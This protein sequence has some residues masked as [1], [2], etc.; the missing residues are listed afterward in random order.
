MSKQIQRCLCDGRPADVELR[1]KFRPLLLFVNS[2]FVR[3]N[4]PIY[5]VV[6]SDRADFLAGIAASGCGS[7]F[8]I[9][10]D[11]FGSFSYPYPDPSPPG[12]HDM[13]GN[14]NYL[15]DDDYI[16]RYEPFHIDDSCEGGPPGN[17]TPMPDNNSVQPANRT[18][19]DEPLPASNNALH[20]SGGSFDHDV[21]MHGDDLNQPV[22]VS[23]S[24]KLSPDTHRNAPG[25]PNLEKLSARARRNLVRI[26]DEARQ[27]FGKSREKMVGH[28]QW[29]ASQ[30]TPAG[31]EYYTTL[32]GVDHAPRQLLPPIKSSE[33]KGESLDNDVPMDDDRSAQSSAAEI[34]NGTPLSAPNQ[35]PPPP[36]V[37]HSPKTSKQLIEVT[38]EDLAKFAAYSRRLCN[39]SKQKK[40]K[41]FRWA[42]KFMTSAELQMYEELFDS[43]DPGNRTES[44][45]NKKS[46]EETASDLRI[47]KMMKLC[48][49]KR[50]ENDEDQRLFHAWARTLLD[51]RDAQGFDGR[52][53]KA[54][55]QRRLNQGLKP[56]DPVETEGNP[57]ENVGSP[58]GEH[59][60]PNGVH[61]TGS[62]ND[63]NGTSNMEDAV[64]VT[65]PDQSSLGTIRRMLVRELKST[66][67]R[68]A[69]AA[70]ISLEYRDQIE[71]LFPSH[72][73]LGQKIRTMQQ[74]NADAIAEYLHRIDPD[75]AVKEHIK[76]R[77]TNL[78]ELVKNVRIA[79]M[80]ILGAPLLPPQRC[81]MYIHNL[82]N[83]LNDCHSH[84]EPRKVGPQLMEEFKKHLATRRHYDVWRASHSS[85]YQ[86][87]E[88][89]FNK[90]FTDADFE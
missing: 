85:T 25:K 84:N 78:D 88:S 1:S 24:D 3:H 64:I 15:D 20:R 10:G 21:S 87:F 54:R 44:Q 68:L 52:L 69:E 12:G 2:H 31:F 16:D 72:T 53:S 80:D 33:A 23:M 71:F 82:A 51:E 38:E 90:R 67:A 65:E 28:L 77:N 63:K 46:A 58:D 55:L 34:I 81:L 9:G 4:E 6:M 11:D 32:I 86:R 57:E 83:F 56:S 19:D 30:F 41:H 35:S 37:D 61:S 7:V 5:L 42:T 17:H 79:E 47:K 89:Y 45:V 59:V 50:R 75:H 74:R 76:Q 60:S 43:S 66:L 39:N 26:A 8:G 70:S 62:A 29:A 40:K 22:D 36:T 27:R 14:N 73:P 49:E 13:Y 48:G 18:M